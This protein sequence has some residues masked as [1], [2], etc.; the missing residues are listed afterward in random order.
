MSR[1]YTLKIITLSFFFLFIACNHSSQKKEKPKLVIFIVIDQM[2][3]EYLYRFQDN[4]SEDGFKLLLREGFNVK[5]T[6]YN[7]IPTATAPGHSSIYTGTTPSEHGIIYNNWFDRKENKMINSAE[8]TSVFLVDNSGIIKDT[9]SKKFQRSPKNLKTTTITDELKLFTNNRAKVIS[10]SIKD[11]GAIFPGGHLADYAFWYNNN[12]GHF[13][14]S[15]Y[16]IEELPSWLKK[17]NNKKIADSLLNLT[18]NPLLPIKHYKNSSIDNASFEKVFN[19]REKSTFPYTLK[20]LRKNNGNYNLLPQIPQGNTLLTELFK[21]SIKGEKLGKGNETDFLAISFS[22]TDYI[23]HNFG[24]RSKEIEDTYLRMD[25]E[26]AKIIKT[27]NK[28]VG[29]RKYMLVLTSD[30]GS[31]DNPPFL[32]SNHL[33]GKFI[34]SKEIRIKLNTYLS[35]EIFPKDYISYIDKTQIYLKKDLKNK[36]EVLKKSL[37]FLKRMEGIK[38]VFIPNITTFNKSSKTTIFR[39]SFNSK[40]SGDIMYQVVPGWMEKRSYGT[41]HTTSYNNDTHVPLIWYGYNIRKGET[42]L[43][44]KITQIAPTLSMLL[45]I[46]FPNASNKIPIDDIIENTYK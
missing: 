15:S 1:T 4:Y 32:N 23:G 34:S 19:G 31:S 22:S 46:P 27:L 35:K 11:R 5:N 7:Y 38:D 3:A 2:R 20:E 18:W 25:R 40:V 10:I 41:T 12:N 14:T 16:Y 28:E 45:D 9:R 17:F 42:A 26:I 36:E 39:N 37:V 43:S 44:V 6:H 24:I 30:H 13:I 21:A 33:P 8:D 29:K